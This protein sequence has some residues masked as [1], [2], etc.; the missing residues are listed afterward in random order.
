[1]VF[2]RLNFDDSEV[3][4]AVYADNLGIMQHARRIIFQL[5]PDAV[6]AIHHV[7][8]GD[9]VAI[10]I[11]DHARAQ[12]ALAAS[13]RALWTIALFS[14]LSALPTEKAVKEILKRVLTVIIRV[15]R[16]VAIIGIVT[17]IRIRGT[18]R[19]AARGL[20]CAFR[21]DVH[22]GWLKLLGHLPKGIAEL[23]RGLH[24]QQRGIGSG[25]RASSHA[26][27]ADHRTDQD[28]NCKSKKND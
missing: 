27:S 11:H 8:I 19:A 1:M 25:R 3:G 2:R 4:L 12:R 28:T 17:V 20:G 6:S 5:Y 23:L 13:A 26:V 7:E 15:I 18:A 9:N 24:G 22:H 16:I 10:G 14:A 21:V